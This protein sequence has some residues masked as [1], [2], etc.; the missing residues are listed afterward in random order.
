LTIAF[1][2]GI[3]RLGVAICPCACGIRTCG[4]I[5]P[6]DAEKSFPR[7]FGLSNTARHGQ[8]RGP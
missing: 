7:R 4:S 8:I 2:A 5:N 3:R 1:D 6:A